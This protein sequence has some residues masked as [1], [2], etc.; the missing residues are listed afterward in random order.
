[1]AKFQT[2]PALDSAQR[3]SINEASALLRQCRAKT[4]QDIA[5]DRLEAFK[6]GRRT[7]VTGRSIIARSTPEQAVRSHGTGIASSKGQSD[8][9]PANK[10]RGTE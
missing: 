9:S 6:D 4:Y 10:S 3:Y 5:A 2:L 1:M 7:Y 8:A